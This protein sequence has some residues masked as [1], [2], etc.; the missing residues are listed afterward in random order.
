MQLMITQQTRNYSKDIMQKF[1]DYVS[2]KEAVDPVVSG[3]AKLQAHLKNR[4]KIYSGS[5]SVSPQEFGLNP[6]E[7]E[8]LKMRGAVT[9]GTIE[10]APLQQM[11]M[12]YQS[13]Q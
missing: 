4:V 1:K 6:Q 3:L 12:R 11:F 7:I 9:D 8:A 5:L 13:Q 10:L 2:L